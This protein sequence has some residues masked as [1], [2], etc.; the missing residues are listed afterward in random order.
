MNQQTEI[1]LRGMQCPTPI[2][3]LNEEIAKLEAGELMVAVA[4]DRAFALDVEAWCE[5]TGNNLV[6]I[7]SG[8]ETD[9]KVTI[10][11]I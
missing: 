10:E 6:T 1:D 4:D 8:H 2:V 5:L 7:D 9:I 3:K 11:K